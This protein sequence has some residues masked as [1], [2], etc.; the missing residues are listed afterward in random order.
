MRSSTSN[1]GEGENWLP[2]SGEGGSV[3]PQEPILEWVEDACWGVEVVSYNPGQELPSP[4][5]RRPGGKGFLS[6]PPPQGNYT[7]RHPSKKDTY[8]QNL[9]K[10]SKRRVRTASGEELLPES[11]VSIDVGGER[12]TTP[13]L[14]SEKVDRMLLG[15]LTLEAPSI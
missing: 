7:P 1:L 14:I 12:T 6:P 5:P 10:S 4:H 11:Y 15:V 8:S 13:V 9:P 2:L 3:K